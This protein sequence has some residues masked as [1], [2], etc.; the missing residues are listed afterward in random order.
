MKSL[1]DIPIYQL[2]KTSATPHR[3][4]DLIKDM[5]DFFVGTVVKNLPANEGNTGSIPGLG[6]FHLS[7]SS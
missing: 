5:G 7:R 2:G 1:Q 4:F 3:E 6:R